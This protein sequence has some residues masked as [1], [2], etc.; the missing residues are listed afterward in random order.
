LAGKKTQ[1]VLDAPI[2]VLFPIKSFVKTIA[3]DSGKEFAL[4]EKIAEASLGGNVFRA[5]DKLN[6]ALKVSQLQNTS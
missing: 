1:S 6:G 3:F 5:V 4:H 2:L